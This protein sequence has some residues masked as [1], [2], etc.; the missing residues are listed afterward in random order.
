MHLNNLIPF[1]ITADFA[2][3]ILLFSLKSIFLP[4]GI[5]GVGQNK[6]LGDRL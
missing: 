2:L 4:D 6:S 3:L 5:E 1:L